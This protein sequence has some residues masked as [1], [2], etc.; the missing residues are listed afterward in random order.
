MRR[1]VLIFSLGLLACEDPAPAKQT[2]VEQNLTSVR[3]LED[4]VFIPVKVV[5]PP[6]AHYLKVIRC[7]NSST[8]TTYNCGKNCNHNITV[9]EAPKDMAEPECKCHKK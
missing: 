4:C 6:Q 8:T 7:P 3:G 2:N 1:L 5:E 9:T